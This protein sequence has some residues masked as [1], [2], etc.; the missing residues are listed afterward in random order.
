M[1]STIPEI[2]ANVALCQTSRG[3]A[4]EPQYGNGKQ[5]CRVGNSI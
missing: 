1:T 3:D 4:T 2:A 5:R